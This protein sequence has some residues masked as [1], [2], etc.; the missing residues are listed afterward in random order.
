MK[1]LILVATIAFTLTTAILG[2]NARGAV[3][4][5]PE[6]LPVT[7]PSFVVERA[8]E[9]TV[10]QPESKYSI[11]ESMDQFV[12]YFAL[13]NNYMT[14]AQAKLVWGIFESEGTN[15]IELA[16]ITVDADTVETM[17]QVSCVTNFRHLNNLK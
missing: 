5:F 14:L 4:P 17:A 9:L 6:T 7:S 13:N 10:F 11:C 12:T 3:N 16:G 2:H 15:L 8:E 1:N